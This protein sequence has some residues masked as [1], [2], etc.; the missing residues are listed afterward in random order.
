MTAYSSP[1]ATRRYQSTAMEKPTYEN[2][3]HTA[4]QGS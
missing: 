2:I 1:L 4:H 3:L